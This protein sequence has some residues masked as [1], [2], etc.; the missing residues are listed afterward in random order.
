MTDFANDSRGNALPAFRWGKCHQVSIGDEQELSERFSEQTSV[1]AVLSTV[2]FRFKL[3]VNPVASDRCPRILANM[4]VP[5]RVFA[6]ER[7]SILSCGGE[8]QIEITEME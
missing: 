8:G 5:L 1:V 4:W 7:I 6:G 2:D 3:G